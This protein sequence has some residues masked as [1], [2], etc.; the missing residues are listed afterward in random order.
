MT[1]DLSASCPATQQPET[2]RGIFVRVLESQAGYHLKA[3]PRGLRVLDAII[4]DRVPTALASNKVDCT[5][6]RRADEELEHPAERT[7]RLAEMSPTGKH[8]ATGFLELRPRCPHLFPPLLPLIQEQVERGCIAQQTTPEQDHE[9]RAIAPAYESVTTNAKQSRGHHGNVLGQLKNFS[10]TSPWPLPVGSLRSRKMDSGKGRLR[11]V[12]T[13][14]QDIKANNK[15]CSM[16]HIH[17][18]GELDRQVSTADT[19]CL[20]RP[21]LFHE[22]TRMDVVHKGTRVKR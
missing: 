1:C 5:T 14:P 12:A 16:S 11:V 6:V 13:S 22:R 8:H 10:G 17:V 20:L 3:A 19:I 2:S 18:I 15:S 21:L 7:H 4:P 9:H